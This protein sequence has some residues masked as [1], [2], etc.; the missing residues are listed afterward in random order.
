VTAMPPGKL[1]PTTMQ[2]PRRVHAVAACSERQC[3]SVSTMDP[4][5]REK[6]RPE[7]AVAKG[8]RVEVWGEVDAKLE[9]VAASDRDM[10]RVVALAVTCAHDRDAVV[11][12]DEDNRS[13]RWTALVVDGS[14]LSIIARSG[15]G[16]S[17]VRSPAIVVAPLVTTCP[18]RGPVKSWALIF[19]WSADRHA[20]VSGVSKTAT[21]VE[22]PFEGFVTSATCLENKRMCLACTTQEPLA[23]TT[24]VCFDA[25]KRRVVEEGPWRVDHVSPGA[26][27]C[28]VRQGSAVACVA[29]YEC[30]LFRSSNGEGVGVVTI[31]EPNRVVPCL[32][33]NLNDAVVVCSATG[34]E[35]L[36]FDEHGLAN[37]VV[38]S[39]VFDCAARLGDRCLGAGPAGAAVVKFSGDAASTTANVL[40]ASG[41]VGDACLV[42]DRVVCVGGGS[43]WS[44]HERLVD[45]V[46]Y[47]LTV[48]RHEL[49]AAKVSNAT[50]VVA[51]DVAVFLKDAGKVIK[52]D[53]SD[54]LCHG[55]LALG[56]DG[57]RIV[58]VGTDGLRTCDLN[59]DCVEF[60]GT[61]VVNRFCCASIDGGRIVAAGR[62]ELVSV[63][64][65]GRKLASKRLPHEIHAVHV[66]NTRVAV[67]YG[68][69]VGVLALDTLDT[70]E[71]VALPA[72]ASDV[73]IL[74]DGTLAACLPDGVLVGGKRVVVKRA[75]TFVSD[76]IVRTG[77]GAVVNYRD[78]CQLGTGDYVC[79][80]KD[81][82]RRD[83]RGRV[84][85]ASLRNE[86]LAAAVGAA[87]SVASI[88]DYLVAAGGTSVRFYD[89]AFAEVCSV[90]L[91]GAVIALCRSR[92]PEGAPGVSI[93][94]KD[95]L[96]V[97]EL[98]GTNGRLACIALGA[99][100]FDEAPR[101]AEAFDMNIAVAAGASVHV[102][103]WENSG[104]SDEAWRLPSYDLKVLASAEAASAVTALACTKSCVAVAAEGHAVAV[105]SYHGGDLQM[106]ALAQ[107]PSTVR[108]LGFAGSQLILGCDR[109]VKV[110]DVSDE[111]ARVLG[112]PGVAP[113]V[114]RLTAGRVCALSSPARRVL[115]GGVVVCASGGVISLEL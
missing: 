114:R 56:F 98:R 37:R 64:A 58:H 74:K 29:A 68:L 50:L 62:D 5:W 92:G 95:A 28:A 9:L 3:F 18:D 61:Y 73:R 16:I 2:P 111:S 33:M 84:S 78:G 21:P 108:C 35:A 88:G 106:V 103:G 89:G 14:N 80:G 40:D 24:L 99:C 4:Q 13:L 77:D 22:T 76:T 6:W 55:T 49:F 1:H 39:K 54:L 31:D 105:F 60:H 83:G 102:V 104:N 70:T 19:A 75:L 82:V 43:L 94:T 47:D 42:H 91:A 96:A 20:A 10:E 81:F 59:G 32:V 46:V 66:K 17:G 110:L 41:D 100:E 85:R 48:P 69:N 63:D 23:T 45:D 26:C 53:L 86:I 44:T 52:S 101:C 97:C 67:A 93:I 7:V 107:D 27:V 71:Q 65:S 15:F 30:R 109:Y 79:T 8:D 112:P 87:T 12:V 25:P 115:S 11:V 36:R 38:T 113:C 34:T 51:G 72:P 90:E 57:N